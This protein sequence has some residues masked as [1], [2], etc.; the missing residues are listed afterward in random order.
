MKLFTSHSDLGMVVAAVRRELEKSSASVQPNSSPINVEYQQ[1][2]P[3][4]GDFIK[5]KL[6][7]LDKEDL[8]D[9]LDDEGA[10]EKFLDDLSYP[11]LDT[12]T[13]SISSME[14]SIKTQAENNLQIQTEIETLRD[15]LL[16]KVQDYHSK[17]SE[18]EKYYKRLSEQKEKVSGDVMAD[19][20]IRLSVDNEE[21]SDQIADKFLSKELGV[22]EFL[23]S[24]IKLRTDCHLQ[25]LKA[26]KVKKLF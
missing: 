6:S 14:D 2:Q 22:E 19:K 5:N 13:D 25:K 12:I 20:L 8:Q 11:P 26:D 18:L 24:Y 10:L 17:K 4:S 1:Q 21:E 9:I 16:N 23:Q 3:T 7:E 15:S